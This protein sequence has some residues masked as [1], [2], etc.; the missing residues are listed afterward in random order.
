MAGAQ[1]GQRQRRAPGAAAEHGDAPAALCPAV[2]AL[3]AGHALAPRRPEPT[4]GRRDAVQR[5]ARARHEIEAVLLR[6]ARAQPLDAGPGDHRR[7]VGAEFQRRRDE[8]E[9]G[10]V[11][12]PLQCRLDRAVGGDAAGN[13]Q[14]RIFRAGKRFAKPRSALAKH[15]RPAHRPPP[16]GTRRRCRRRP[17]RS[18]A[19]WP[20]PPGARRSSGRRRKNRAAPSPSSGAGRQSAWHRRSPPPSRHSVRRDRA[21]RASWPSCRR[22]RRAHRRW[23]SPSAGS[24]RRRARR[25]S[26]C[27]RRKP[28]AADRESRARRSALR[29]A[30]GLRDG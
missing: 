14:R 5:P 17:G 15:G 24:R 1:H 23:S 3:A 19:Q 11:A 21:G 27:G 22:L 2:H 28:A 16:P 4:I 12:Q 9:A 20:S 25:R 6:H 8:G 26:A 10:L 7:I 30:R 29:S 18:A 13:D